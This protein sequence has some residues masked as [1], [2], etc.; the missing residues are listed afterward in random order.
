MP[1]LLNIFSAL[2]LSSAAGLNAYIPM[3]LL[4]IMANRGYVHL[5]A[6]YDV[7]G[8]WWAIALLVVLC[9]IELVVDKI[10]GADHINDMI[11][12]AIRPTAGAILFASQTG[13]ISHVHPGVW[14]TIGILTAGGVHA[15]K[16]IA[17]PVVNFGT[18]GIGTP[19]VSSIENMVSTVVSLLAILAPI[20]CMIVMCVF[21]WLMFKA[22][23]RF[24]LRPRTY[25]VRAVAV[26]ERVGEVV[27]VPVREWD[28]GV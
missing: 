24:V 2:G 7:L 11:Q 16:S 9:I 27:V 3:L 12:T 6:P 8:S 28:G 25:R 4:S 23:R 13:V 20:A 1:E 14:L 21:G 10:P 15:T 22:F 26:E 17:R 18:V 5:A 19:I